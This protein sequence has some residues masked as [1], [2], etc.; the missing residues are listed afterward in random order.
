MVPAAK[1]SLALPRIVLLIGTAFG[2]FYLIAAVFLFS[3]QRKMLFFPSGYE[4]TWKHGVP[5]ETV[6]LAS[7]TSQGER[8]IA[9]YIP[10][11]GAGKDPP[12][13]IWVMFHGNA[14][15]ALGWVDEVDRWRDEQTGFLLVDYPGYGLCEGKPTRGGVISSAELAWNAFAAHVGAHPDEVE[16]ELNV[17]GFSLGAAAAL[18]FASRHEARSLVLMAPFTSVRD[19][20][21]RMV[22]PLF[23]WL[24]VDRFDNAERLAELSRSASPPDVHL[25]HATEDE[26]IP[27]EMSETLAERFPEMITLH[28]IEG[29]S[30]NWLLQ[31]ARDQL[32]S[33]VKGQ[34]DM[35]FQ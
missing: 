30:H 4:P 33:I 35:G 20:A 3:V 22:T 23:S 17:L 32:D 27:H 19:M 8:L 12:Q 5:P 34:T 29:G 7:T 26:V 24:A 13:R 25:F 11:V 6:E 21:S 9:F 10:P 15:R 16:S 1:A 18:E 2:A 28:S 14:S 31:L